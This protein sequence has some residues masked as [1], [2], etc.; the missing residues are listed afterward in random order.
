MVDDSY[1][2]LPEKGTFLLAFGLTLPPSEGKHGVWFE[3]EGRTAS[4][5]PCSPPTPPTATSAPVVWINSVLCGFLSLLSLS[6]GNK[7]N[8][9]LQIFDSIIYVGIFKYV[10]LLHFK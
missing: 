7:D 8:F 10:F 3:L 2:A 5:S 4:L 6:E 1:T 9:S